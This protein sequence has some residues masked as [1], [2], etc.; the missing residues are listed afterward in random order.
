MLEAGR[1]RHRVR[2]ERPVQVQDPQTGALETE[3]RV[4]HADV[5]AA[6]EPLSVR[7]FMAAQQMQS[8]ITARVVIRYLP[9]LTAD[10]RLR[11]GARILNPQ[12]FLAD[13]DSGVEY[14]TI[15]CTE[16]TNE[17]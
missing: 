5:P 1:L 15:P 13:K 7:E 14:L 11:I 17:G 12:G 2:I 6:I 10:M 8:A 16:G 4:M 9:G 3:W